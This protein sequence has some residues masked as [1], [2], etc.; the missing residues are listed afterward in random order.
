MMQGVGVRSAGFFWLLLLVLALA[1]CRGS[2]EVAREPPAPS[3]ALPLVGAGPVPLEPEEDGGTGSVWFDEVREPLV[4]EADDAQALVRFVAASVL[5]GGAAGMGGVERFPFPERLQKDRLPRVVFLSLS[6]GVS[7]VRVVVGTGAGLSGAVAQALER[8]HALLERER[9]GPVWL[10]V[11]VVQEVVLQETVPMTQPL[12]FEPSL[13]GLAFDRALG[14][15]FLPEELVAHALVDDEQRIRGGTM[16]RFLVADPERGRAFASFE[17]MLQAR[18]GG[19]RRFQFTTQGFFL[20]GHEDLVVPLYRGHRMFG[21]V[22]NEDLVQ[23]AVQGGDYL[24]RSVGTDG[25]FRYSYEPQTGRVRAQYN[26]LRHA[27]TVSAMLEVYEMTGDA[28]VLTAVR[29]AVGYLVRS[30]QSCATA[31]GELPCVVEDGSTK[32]GGNALAVVAL[33]RYVEA[34]GDETVRPLITG[35]GQWI[36]ANQGA[37]GAFL[38]HKQSFPD[39]AVEDFVSEYYPGEALL[40]LV[41]LSALDGDEHWLDAAEAGSQFLIEGRDGGVADEDLPHDHW[42]LYALHELYRVRSDPRYLEHARRIAGAIVR[43]QNHSPVYPDWWG[44]FY[45]PPRSTPT[46]TRM[47][48]VCAAALLSR[49]VGASREEMERLRAALWAGAAFQL[50]TQFRPETVMY[51]SDPQSALGGFHHSLT[52]FEI[53]IDYVQHNISSLL[54]LAHLNG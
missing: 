19:V 31:A 54:C 22:S 53:R 52:D 49:K 45:D 50:Q 51:L 18:P 40:A 2:G 1:A 13:H 11:D 25:R 28:A 32:L 8:S 3:P 10:K 37:D 6:D 16:A 20:D 48:G 7:P 9:L 41:R 29:R 30:V 43:S 44:S 24:V 26:I 14:V 4:L 42:L 36:R 21:Q 46:A 17:Q 27:G 23:A 15:A 34:T 35:L 38:V 12:R 5:D 33:A 39:G 47:E